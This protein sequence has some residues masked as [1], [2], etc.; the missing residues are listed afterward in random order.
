MVKKFNDA[1]DCM[2]IYTMVIRWFSDVADFEKEVISNV[3][4]SYI[5]KYY[6]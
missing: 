6:F 5:Y 4:V 3:F 1:R 2:T